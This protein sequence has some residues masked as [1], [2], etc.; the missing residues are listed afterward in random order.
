RNTIIN[1]QFG[2]ELWFTS[3]NNIISENNMINNFN[4]IIIW[5]EGEGNIIDRNYWSKY[6]G[7]DNNGDGIGDTPHIFFEN[8]QD[9]NP[10]MKI[11]VI[12]EFPSWIILPLFIV[13][14]LVGIVARNK[15]RKKEID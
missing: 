9:H 15:I 8:Y 6:D 14:S 3:S 7:T 10:L 4:D 5:L 1:N 2:I 12:P 13:A 11:V